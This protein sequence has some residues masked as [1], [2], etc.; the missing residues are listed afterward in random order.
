LQELFSNAIYLQDSSVTIEGIKIYGSPYVENM[1]DM[2]GENKEFMTRYDNRYFYRNTSEL[3]ALFGKIE[4]DTN[5]LITHTPPHGV[6]DGMLHFG[7]KELTKRISQLKQLKVN[8]FGHVH[9]GYGIKKVD[10]VTYINAASDGDEQPI[11]FDYV[12]PTQ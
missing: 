7:S 5:I 12:I 4:E 10:H 6:L 1:S 3:E 2:P 8:T 11:Y 9:M